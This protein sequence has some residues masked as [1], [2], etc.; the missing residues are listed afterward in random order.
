M[1]NTQRT[2]R[3]WLKI[4]LAAGAVLLAAVIVLTMT[5]TRTAAD[6]SLLPDRAVNAPVYR[7]EPLGDGGILTVGETGGRRLLY[8]RE[9][10]VFTVEDIATGAVWSTGVEEDYFTPALQ[11]PVVRKDMRKLCQVG[12]TDFAGKDDSFSSARTDYQVTEKRLE[13][14]IALELA[15]PDY[16]IGFTLEV[17]LNAYGLCT[18][19]P[20]DSLKETG[21]YGLTSLSLFPMLGAALDSEDG[22]IVYPDGSGS[23]FTFERGDTAEGRNPIT[24][25]VYFPA[26]FDL[27]EVEA[28]DQSRQYSLQLPAYG[29]SRGRTAMAAYILDGDTN[30]T[31]TANPSGYIYEINRVNATITYRKSY[32]Y[33]TP[34]NIEVTEMERTISA[35]DYTVQYLF[36]QGEEPVSYGRLAGALRTFLLETGRLHRVEAA[37]MTTNLQLLM[38]TTQ[39]SMLGT[40]FVELTAYDDAR[41]IVAS[42]GDATQDH[43]RVLLLGWEKKG[44]GL[45]PAGDSAAWQL[46][47]AG[48]L[49]GLNAWLAER[50][51]ASYLVVNTVDASI[52]GAGFN[53]NAQAVY[54]ERNLPLTNAESDRFLLNPLLELQALVKGRLSGYAKLNGAGVAFDG[55]G[56]RLYDDYRE[57]RRLTR[58]QASGA[59]A[60]MMARTA[61]AGMRAGA[62]AGN[63]YVLPY[64]DYLYDLPQSNAG[65]PLLK[66]AIPF[67]Q[68]VVHGSIPY[69]GAVPGNMAPD[70]ETEKLRWIE[71]G[72]EPSFLLQYQTSDRLKGSY[73]TE[74]FAT[75]YANWVQTIDR[76]AAEFRGELGFTAGQAM[77]DH[78][79]ADN[80]MVIVTYEQGER[81]YINYG[82]APLTADGVTVPAKSYIVVR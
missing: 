6:Y 38:G 26:S 40:S 23:L 42:L 44:Y 56:R 58:A 81:I 64:A 73:V 33:V 54:N 53:Q 12:F 2:G 72:C 60:A 59:F 78:R 3:R 67:Y 24:T 29:I 18:R 45:Y 25:P 75:D 11:V 31:I 74:A 49:K 77:I 41:R 48:K 5:L 51:I 61:A 8:D 39:D 68:M 17:W 32:S 50:S 66:R 15:F 71:Y 1:A 43:L 37:A 79:V 36:M 70:F 63:A 14:G 47:G 20:A 19:V 21:T 10:V 16:Q 22:Y 30:C 82:A 27:D 57:D 35:G 52:K 62:Q 4:G 9:N 28:A 76:C 13:N 34:S 46:G 55:I 69:S 80:G 65:L 7:D